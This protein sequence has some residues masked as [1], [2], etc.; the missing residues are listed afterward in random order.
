MHKKRID[1]ARKAALQTGKTLLDLYQ[2]G[3]Q[4]GYLK[5]DHS[6]SP[7]APAGQG[8]CLD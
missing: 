1:L 2:K 6:P 8:S 4:T 3:D 5:E 7:D